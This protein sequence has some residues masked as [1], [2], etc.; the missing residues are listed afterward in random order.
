MGHQRFNSQPPEGGWWL[1]VL[2]AGNRYEFQLAAA[3]RRLGVQ[4]AIDRGWVGVSTRSRP[5]AAGP[6]FIKCSHEPPVSTR[7]RPKAAGVTMIMGD[8]QVIVS[9]R[10]RPKAAGTICLVLEA[11]FKCFNSQPPEGGWMQ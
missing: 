4:I 11:P 2:H 1:R 6:L 7:S 8:S 9:T 5:K 3:R 10:S